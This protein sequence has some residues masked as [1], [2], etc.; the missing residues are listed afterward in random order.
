MGFYSYHTT[1]ASLPVGFREQAIHRKVGSGKPEDPLGNGKEK[2]LPF[3]VEKK[4]VQGS[5]R[6]LTHF[7]PPKNVGASPLLR[8]GEK[9]LL[10]GLAQ[11]LYYGR[12]R[13]EEGA[14]KAMTGREQHRKY[15]ETVK[16]ISVL[17]REYAK[18]AEKISSRVFR[19]KAAYERITGIAAPKSTKK[20]KVGP[21]ELGK[22][23]ADITTEMGRH[24]SFQN[25]LPFLYNTYMIF[26]GTIFEEHLE[27]LCEKEVKDTY[28]STDEALRGWKIQAQQAKERFNRL[29]EKYSKETIDTVIDS[30]HFDLLLKI[31]SSEIQGS[32]DES[33]NDS[34]SEDK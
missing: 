22:H 13:E 9:H 24:Q 14:W 17:H 16:R 21:T 31:P 27:N 30:N 25:K 5:V 11:H 1:V 18:E 6:T 32:D 20:K 3:T 19:R 34:E 29:Q 4:R 2:A 8:P 15:V 26:K 23:L 33:V 7:T 12:L 10:K 28:F